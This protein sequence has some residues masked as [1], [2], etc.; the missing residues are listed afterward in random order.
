M[1]RAIAI[2]LTLVIGV[3]G[4]KAV[5]AIAHHTPDTNQATDELFV[6]NDVGGPAQTAGSGTR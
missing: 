3:A 4:A 5:G 6:P 1:R 2:G